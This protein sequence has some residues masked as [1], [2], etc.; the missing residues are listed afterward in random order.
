LPDLINWT[1]ANVETILLVLF[2]SLTMAVFFSFLVYIRAE[3][4][5]C[6]VVNIKDNLAETQQMLRRIK[7]DY[8]VSTLVIRFFESISEG[9]GSGVLYHLLIF[10]FVSTLYAGVG[11]GSVLTS[12]LAGRVQNRKMTVFLGL[13]A[14]K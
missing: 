7:Q 1:T 13:E 11:F 2:Y 8:S 5:S 9:H 12:V 6:S 14:K 3:T 4:R 10:C